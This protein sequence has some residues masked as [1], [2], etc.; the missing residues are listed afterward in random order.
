MVAG[1]ARAPPAGRPPVPVPA[2]RSPYAGCFAVPA[3]PATVPR[4][5]ALPAPIRMILVP[6]ASGAGASYA[7]ASSTSRTGALVRSDL[8][9][10]RIFLDGGWRNVQLRR[11]PFRAQSPRRPASQQR[12]RAPSRSRSSSRS[13]WR[14]CS[15]LASLFRFFPRACSCFF[16]RAL[17]RSAPAREDVRLH[18]AFLRSCRE[19]SASARADV[20]VRVDVA[21]LFTSCSVAQT[22]TSSA[23]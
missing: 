23:R 13:F 17:S 12:A 21:S 15:R 8:R 14:C 10:N 11:S 5:R 20:P 18:C 9:G 7:G 6:A 2:A 3:S 1:S 4:M 22:S 19:T 16:S